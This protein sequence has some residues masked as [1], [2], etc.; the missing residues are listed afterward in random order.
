MICRN[1][2]TEVKDENTK[3]CPQCGNALFENNSK[4]NNAVSSCKAWPE[5]EIV[6]QLGRGSFGTVYKAVRRDSYFETFSAIK[7]V[8]IPSDSSEV[9][10]LQSEGLD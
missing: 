8:R 1:C 9:K 3:F 10:A 5:W 2:G 7:E 4:N 6:E